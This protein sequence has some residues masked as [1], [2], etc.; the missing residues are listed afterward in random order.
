MSDV[1][2]VNI[3]PPANFSTVY[4]D[5]ITNINITTNVVKLYLFRNDPSIDGSAQLRQT[6]FA[7]L[8][9]PLEAFIPTVIFLSGALDDMV[10]QG[11]VAQSQ[12]DTLKQQMDDAKAAMKEGKRD[13]PGT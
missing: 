10:A 13:A 9:L 12:V 11:T 2:P 6:T 3:F 5:G 1:P 7:Q 8:V 4:I